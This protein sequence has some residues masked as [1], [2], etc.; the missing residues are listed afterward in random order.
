MWFG[1]TSS[2]GKLS[3]NDKTVVI[4]NENILLVDSVRDLGAY[5][6]PEFSMWTHVSRITQLCFY[7]LQRLRQICHLL[8]CDV[9]SSLVAALILFRLDYCNA[10]LARLPRTTIAPLQQVINAAARL[11]FNL[12]PRDPVLLALIELHWLPV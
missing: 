10:L 8:G 2:L 5:L 12:R 3:Q 11:V 7:Q 4:G 9:T 6:D 1:S